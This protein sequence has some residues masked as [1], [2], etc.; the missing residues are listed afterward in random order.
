MKRHLLVIAVLTSAA[1]LACNSTTTD[2]SA[3]TPAASTPQAS[4]A[5]PAQR[6]PAP[7][8]PEP[9]KPV[10]VTV[11]AGTILEMELADPLSTKTNVAGDTFK[12]KVV[13][14]VSVGGRVVIPADSVVEGSVTQS[15][16]AKKMSGQAALSLQFSKLIL[17]SGQSVA[18]SGMLSEK[19]KKIGSRTGGIIGG[20]AAGGAVLG[21]IIGKDTKGA[22][23]GAVLGAAVGT[24]IAA[25]QKGQELKLPAGTGLSIELASDAEV[26]MP[27]QQG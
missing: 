5:K 25:S 20:S 11:P 24:G 16:S 8:P 22:V 2:Q 21:R 7:R 4:A 26:S 10:M 19:G 12:A 15:V 9:P 17:P 13:E 23:V 6:P 1:L 27:P 14:A 18:I 3:E